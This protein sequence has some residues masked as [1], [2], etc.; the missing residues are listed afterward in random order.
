MIWFDLM[1]LPY[2]VNRKPISIT[3]HLG[4]KLDF[5]AVPNT[6][7]NTNTEF[8]KHVMSYIAMMF[9]PSV[10][11]HH[12][13]NSKKGVNRTNLLKIQKIVV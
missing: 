3:N 10:K 2:T 12:Q 11:A 9:F 5:I 8:C 13:E 6:N 4:P 1:A 7:T